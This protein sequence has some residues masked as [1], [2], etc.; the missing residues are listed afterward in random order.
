M[1]TKVSKLKC[2]F[3]VFVCLSLVA[4]YSRAPITSSDT[5]PGDY[6]H[7]KEY[8]TWFI[9]Q[10][11]DDQKITG[12]SI[13]LIDDQDI[14]WQQGF[15]FAD[16]EN[17]VKATPQTVYRAGSISKLFTTMA[18][19]KLSGQ[20]KFDI[21]RPLANYLP[22]FSIKSR[23]T[24][25][26]E[27]TSR[28]I[29][30]HHSGLPGNWLKGMWATNPISFSQVV[31][32]IQDE[33]TAYPPNKIFS[34]SN[35][36]FTL[37]GNA[38]QRTAEQDFADYIEQTLLTPLGMDASNFADRLS[39]KSASK[40][41]VN[42]TQITEIPLRDIPAGGLNTTVTDLARLAM[43]IN[44]QGVISD[45]QVLSQKTL[46]AMF[47]EQNNHMPL[48]LDLRIG[49]GWFIDNKSLSEIETVYG[50]GGATIAHRASFMVAPDSR[51]GVVVL[52]N[53]S[54]ANA[55][56]ISRK[57]L[58]LAWQAKSGDE[59]PTS[60]NER[61]YHGIFEPSE[62][63]GTYST[64]IG[65]VDITRKA[66][67]RYQIN[68][69]HGQFTAYPNK[70]DGSFNLKYR[71]FGLI[72]IST[73]LFGDIKVYREN[74]E[75]H[76]L[77]IANLDDEHFIA[78][79]KVKPKQ[80]SNVWKKRIGNYHVTNTIEQEPFFMPKEVELKLDGGFLV[81][82]VIPVKGSN[83]VY[84]LRPE[85]DQEAIIEGLGRNL[86]ETIR[87]EKNENERE[88]IRYSGLTFE[89]LN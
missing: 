35:L 75:R 11:M 78:G 34:Y 2:F 58:Q 45:N 31:S 25:T 21:D 89:K 63:E 23:F 5:T 22:E 30:T 84:I 42:H 28:T 16:L 72:P 66:A 87:V 79:V 1:I 7:V 4:C 71:L 40:S 64:I 10:Q 65:K 50:H 57:L 74:I 49:L 38:I 47:A 76:D 33:Y 80:I 59:L 32:E 8:M 13:A 44:N 69:Q 43:M 51:L 68:T 56:S 41:Y 54:S 27:I 9:K 73:S 55:W 62:L 48:D 6:S 20:G 86:G 82:T 52:A 53:S 77:I 15:G 12:L 24:S 85:N 19:L 67:H 39:G 36:G 60:E 46:S 88:I 3:L 83:D 61:N 14:V 81:I 70:S 17:Q 29:M 26:D 18:A 37:L